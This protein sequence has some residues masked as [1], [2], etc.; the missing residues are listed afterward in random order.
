MNKRATICALLAVFAWSTVATAFKIALRH[1]D[2]FQLLF[3]ANIF[4]LI[5][6]GLVL[7]FGGRW[8]KFQK[9]SPRQFRDAALLGLINPVAYYLILLKAYA[10]LPAQIAQPLNYTW[11]LTLGLLS[12][13]LLG[14]RLTKRDIVGG[15]VCYFGVVVISTG[16]KL[17]GFS[18]VSP[19]GIALALGSTIIWAFYW[20]GNTRLTQG[21]KGMDPVVAL[22]VGF[23]FSLPVVAL[24][25]FFASDFIFTS[26]GIKAAAYIGAVE[27]G[28]TFVL[29]LTAMRLTTSTAKIANLIFLSPFLSLIFIHF[30]L[31]E[32][33]VPGTI[34]GLVFIVGGLLWQSGGSVSRQETK[35]I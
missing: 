35:P 7:A 8:K 25:N 17:T 26:P 2:Q 11:A 4:S 23:A 16:G 22:F 3:L 10:L 29:W 13:P 31:G 9:T 18:I 5:A 6:V 21:E 12:V 24:I 30:L 27:M 20:L 28:F 19:L 34:V 14:Q 1:L 15:L 33:V 32:H